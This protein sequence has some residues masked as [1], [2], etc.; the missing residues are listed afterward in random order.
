MFKILYVVSKRSISFRQSNSCNCLFVGV[1]CLLFSF[2][3]A[4]SHCIAII[5]PIITIVMGCDESCKHM[6][7]SSQQSQINT[8]LLRLG[9]QHVCSKQW[10]GNSSCVDMMLLQLRFP[11][12]SSSGT[13]MFVASN[14]RGT[15]HVSTWCSSNYAFPKL[16][17]VVPLPSS[18]GGPHHSHLLHCNRWLLT[19]SASVFQSHWSSHW[20]IPWTFFPVSILILLWSSLELLRTF[21]TV[22]CK[23]FSDI[24]AS[25]THFGTEKT[26]S[27]ILL[28][29]S[30]STKCTGYLLLHIGAKVNPTKNHA[31]VGLVSFRSS[32]LTLLLSP[33]LVAQVLSC[34]QDEAASLF[35]SW[36]ILLRPGLGLV[37]RGISPGW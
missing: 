27:T 31:P 14:G 25:L 23:I 13:N 29:L 28:V 10:Q 15:H 30:P 36:C 1:S 11:E 21:C 19:V 9:Y 24:L 32:E 4:S 18:L 16:P 8:R 33:S 17:V 2:T 34:E 3:W 26:W 5:T 37:G 22:T 35:I 6:E 20:L 12:A 7:S